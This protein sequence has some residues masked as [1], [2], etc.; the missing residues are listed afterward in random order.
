VVIASH[1]DG[2]GEKPWTPPRVSKSE[3]SNEPEPQFGDLGEVY[4]WKG[5]ERIVWQSP[6]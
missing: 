2:R 6:R 4:S 5:N 1:R 3:V